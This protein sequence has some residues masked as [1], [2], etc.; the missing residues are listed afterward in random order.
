MVTVV[1]TALW[2]YWVRSKSMPATLRT[3]ES[4]PVGRDHQARA[5]VTQHT[6]VAD[7]GARRIRLKVDM[8]QRRRAQPG[9][10]GQLLQTREQ[11]QTEDTGL[12]HVAERLLAE[13]GAGR[14][15]K[16]KRPRSEI[17]IFSIGVA[18]RRV[19]SPHTPMPSKM[20]R[21]PN[22]SAMVRSS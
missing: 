18:P 21:E 20:R 5:E 1:T 8:L 7:A 16:P 15:V 22:A 6:I 3:A 2:P 14:C 4:A 11:R 9:D 12:N 10:V 17:W 13:F 19:A